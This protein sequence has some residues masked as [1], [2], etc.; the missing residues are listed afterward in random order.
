LAAAAV[1]TFSN[2]FIEP[3]AAFGLHGFVRRGVDEAELPGDPS[4][5]SLVQKRN[6]HA[7]EG[8]QN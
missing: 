6:G 7:H 1:A 5:E 2:E 3:Y 8:H 4:P